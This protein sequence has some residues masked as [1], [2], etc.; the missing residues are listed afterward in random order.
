[1]RPPLG[2]VEREPF[3]RPAVKFGASES[4]RRLRPVLALSIAVTVATAP[5]A[6][7][8]DATISITADGP[9]SRRETLRLGDSAAWMNNDSVTHRVRSSPRGFFATR[10]LE[11]GETSRAIPFGSAGSFPYVVL[12]ESGEEG[13]LE[14]PVRLRPGSNASPTPGAV[15]RVRVATER[16]PGRTYDVQRRRDDGRWVTIAEDTRRVVVRFRPRTTGTYWFRARLTIARLGI[17]SRWSPPEDE[18]VVPP[19]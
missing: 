19:P 14:V 10:G 13:L 12:P 2:C 6:R 9:H 5:A 15:I 11:M 3:T 17:T 8:A 16:H 1:M 4:V 18:L 7:A